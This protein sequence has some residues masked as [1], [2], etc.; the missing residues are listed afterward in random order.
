MGYQFVRLRVGSVL[1]VTQQY[2]DHETELPMNQSHEE[3]SR[4]CVCVWEEDCPT[5]RSSLRCGK[6]F[7][8]VIQT[9]P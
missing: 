5:G 6:E 1:E 2:M 3:T 9:K 4:V 8:T 7:T